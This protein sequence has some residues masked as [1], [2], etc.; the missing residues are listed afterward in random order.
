MGPPG[1]TQPPDSQLRNLLPVVEVLDISIAPS[2][3]AGPRRAW[4]AAAASET[5]RRSA[6]RERPERLQ[7]I[8]CASCLQGLATQ[9]ATRSPRCT[10]LICVDSILSNNDLGGIVRRNIRSGKFS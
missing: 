1:V 7:G 8:P 2:G 10:R 4:T 3:L 9:N 5:G 6:V